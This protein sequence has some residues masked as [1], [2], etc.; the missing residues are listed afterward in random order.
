MMDGWKGGRVL[1]CPQYLV[2]SDPVEKNYYNRR[3]FTAEVR[4]GS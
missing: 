2:P 3:V 4:L 1:Y